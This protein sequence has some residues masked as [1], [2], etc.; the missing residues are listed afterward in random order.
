MSSLVLLLACT[1]RP[2]ANSSKDS[3]NKVEIAKPSPFSST[4]KSNPQGIEASTK[5]LSLAE[6]ILFSNNSD[7]LNSYLDSDSAQSNKNNPWVIQEFDSTK[8]YAT[9]SFNGEVISATFWPYYNGFVKV[10]VLNSAKYPDEQSINFT[11][12]VNNSWEELS[13]ERL[14]PN[15]E[16][17]AFILSE[18]ELGNKYHPSQKK[19]GFFYNI[20]KNESSH[21]AYCFTTNCLKLRWSGEIFELEL[22]SSYKNENKLPAK[23]K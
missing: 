11:H 7:L 22:P 9:Y 6:K 14:I 8:S 20:V 2:A 15:Y 10:E 12:F 1:N 23:N 19:Q 17:L 18:I 16:K 5:S 4:L 13:I 3:K 21:L